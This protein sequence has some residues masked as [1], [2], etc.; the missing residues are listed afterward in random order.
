ML[1]IISMGKK[2]DRGMLLIKKKT[3]CYKF[4][5]YTRNFETV[6]GRFLMCYVNC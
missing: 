1:T 6:V 3:T 4:V 5:K 2:T